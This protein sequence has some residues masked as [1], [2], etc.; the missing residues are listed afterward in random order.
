MWN[1]KPGI[2]H[3][4]RW[5]TYVAAETWRDI[6][7]DGKREVAGGSVK[8]GLHVPSMSSHTDC[9]STA[10]L[11]LRLDLFLT[12]KTHWILNRTYKKLKLLFLRNKVLIGTRKMKTTYLQA[13]NVSLWEVERADDVLSQSVH[14][15]ED[16][17]LCHFTT[18]VGDVKHVWTNK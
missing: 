3:I 10:P 17:K 5:L 18:H 6:E 7:G 1:I 4:E 13:G 2:H 12:L 14:G 15:L 16:A 11:E 9:L 8:T